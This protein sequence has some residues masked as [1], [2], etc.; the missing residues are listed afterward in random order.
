MT[1][2]GTVRGTYTYN[3]FDQLIARVITN[4]GTANGTTYFVHDLWGNVIAEL[5]TAV[6]I[7]VEH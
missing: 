4:S 5:T 1:V 2:A 6:S 3:G 7:G